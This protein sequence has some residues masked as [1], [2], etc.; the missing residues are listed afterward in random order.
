MSKKALYEKIFLVLESNYTKKRFEPE[1]CVKLIVYC[2]KKGILLYKKLEKWVLFTNFLNNEI[3]IKTVIRSISKRIRTPI[4]T[5]SQICR[6]ELKSR[7]DSIIKG[8]ICLL[9]TYDNR[10][11]NLDSNCIWV[12][13]IKNIPEN[14]S[15]LDKEL[16]IYSLKNVENIIESK[17]NGDY[18]FLRHKFHKKFISKILYQLSSKKIRCKI[19][20]VL[21]SWNLSPN[22]QYEIIDVSCGYDDLFID[23]WRYFKNSNITGNDLIW[24]PLIKIPKGGYCSNITL[25]NQDILSPNFCQNLNYDLIILK[26]TLHHIPKS[27][28]KSLLQKLFSIGDKIIIVEIENPL[29][30]SLISYLWNFYY[31]HFLHD[32]CTFFLTKEEFKNLIINCI[33]NSVKVSFDSVRT[34]KGNYLFAVIER[35]T[36]LIG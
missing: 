9:K 19:F 27:E 14:I 25:T 16:L 20:N 3:H 18:C 7:I 4:L 24:Q 29:E 17:P 10:N 15:S 6:F 11:I 5:V 2:K 21:K 33:D 34:I 26:N 31:K 12:K 36:N 23:L 1:Q 13:N 8:T 35:K 30:C 32:N 22:G 28:H